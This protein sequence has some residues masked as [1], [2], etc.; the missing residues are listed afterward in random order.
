MILTNKLTL[1]INN[2]VNTR[3]LSVDPVST[4]IEITWNANLDL[5]LTELL[6][7]PVESGTLAFEDARVTVGDKIFFPIAVESASSSFYASKDVSI[8]DLQ[9]TPIVDLDGVERLVHFL[10]ANGSLPL[11]DYNIIITA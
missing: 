2:G 3:V 9:G 11:G 8:S 1:K 6:E 4:R 10:V 7:I 5:Y